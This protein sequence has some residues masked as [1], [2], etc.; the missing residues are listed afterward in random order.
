MVGLTVG[1]VNGHV[2]GHR[3]ANNGGFVDRGF[4]VDFQVVARSQLLDASGGELDDKRA[5]IGADDRL[6]D[7]VVVSAFEH[8]CGAVDA[9][10]LF[11]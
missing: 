8:R 9:A 2:V 7:D 6:G 1:V 4:E 10:T 11:W 5:T 3:D